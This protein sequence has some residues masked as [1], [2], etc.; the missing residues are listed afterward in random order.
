M[1]FILIALKFEGEFQDSGSNQIGVHF[2]DP[3]GFLVDICIMY[4]KEENY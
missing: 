3:S 1:C 2:A 4:D